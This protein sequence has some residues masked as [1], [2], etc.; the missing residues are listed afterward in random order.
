[1][2]YWDSTISVAEKAQQDPQPPADRG[3][4]GLYWI[5]WTAGSYCHVMNV[6]SG[7]N[8][9]VR[10][11]YQYLPSWKWRLEDVRGR[12]VVLMYGIVLLA[13]VNKHQQANFCMV[14]CADAFS[15]ITST[16]I[17]NIIDDRGSTHIGWYVYIPH[18][19]WMDGSLPQLV[20]LCVVSLC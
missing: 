14:V 16:S 9:N 5:G 1:M 19:T 6:M 3:A 8:R 4:I 12:F 20:W 11:N 10:E 18:R 13:N 15:S 7:F 17:A 2:A